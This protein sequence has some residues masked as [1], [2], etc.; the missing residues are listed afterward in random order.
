M[1]VAPDEKPSLIINAARDFFRRVKALLARLSEIAARAELRRKQRVSSKALRAA[2]A[3]AAALE[4]PNPDELLA[5]SLQQA[6]FAFGMDAGAIYLAEEKDG[7]LRL[8]YQHGLPEKLVTEAALVCP[9]EAPVGSAFSRNEVAA[10]PDLGTCHDTGTQT[11]LESGYRS[12]IGAPISTDEKVLGVI[13]LFAKQRR[14]FRKADS[15]SLRLVARMLGNALDRARIHEE[16]EEALVGIRRLSRANLEAPL[17]ADFSQTLENLSRSVSEA[18]LALSSMIVLTDVDGRVIQHAAFGFTRRAQFGFDKTDA[19]ATRVLKTKE[20]VLMSTPT[21]V[22][23]CIGPQATDAGIQSS[24]CLPMRICDGALG[25]LWLNYE[26]PRTFPAWEVEQL[27]SLADR[28]AASVENSRLYSSSVEKAE[29]YRE[30]HE[31]CAKIG[32]ASDLKGVLQALADSAC[33]LLG[34]RTSLAS[35]TGGGFV[36]Q[37]VS[38]AHATQARRL[39]REHATT[40]SELA[41]GSR[42][43][44]SSDESPGALSGAT[45]QA[46][47]NTGRAFLTAPLLDDRN[48]PVGI[49]TVAEKIPEGEFTDEDVELLDA[50]ADHAMVAIRNAMGR[51]QTECLVEEYKALLDRA[52]VALA[53]VSKDQTIAAVNAKFA[54]LTGFTPAEIEGKMSLFDI[55]PETER[56]CPRDSTPES[57]AGEAEHRG[58]AFREQAATSPLLQRECEIT[59]MRKDG[60]QKK[61]KLTV[62]EMQNSGSMAVCLTELE[63]RKAQAGLVE[64]NQSSN[65]EVSLAVEHNVEEIAQKTCAESRSSVAE[66][67]A[68]MSPK[69]PVTKK[70]L[71]IDDERVVV[72]LLDY[73]LRS[74]GHVVETSRDG[75]AALEKLKE[76]DYD[77]VFCD[78]KIPA[79]SGQEVF[80]WLESN[81]PELAQ[82][83]IFITGDVATPETLSFLNH[84]P[85]RWLE[86]PFDLTALRHTIAEVLGPSRE[87]RGS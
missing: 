66:S 59:L 51:R 30:L 35:L 45:N 46:I 71:V 11:W 77:L 36:E 38:S 54:E 53:I 56:A 1:P 25:V 20:P 12:F 58:A 63:E 5:K 69:K 50:L 24:L 17:T 10:I 2:I 44:H 23:D 67:P 7:I 37:A 31:R 52:P 27:Q 82:R 9:G 29:R 64:T 39:V 49:L 43:L 19:I 21:E 86:K 78:L 57:V 70:V 73:F 33:E 6:L 18:A 72:D 81:K 76:N 60:S 62:G 14:A 84:P 65:E 61:V 74:E 3:V 15:R 32:S 40:T 22:T 28:L 16:M 47:A 41:V 79:V 68:M 34:A 8:A 48:D 13:A 55:L 4:S 26:A 85:K 75:R 87:F 80:R 83:V 42:K